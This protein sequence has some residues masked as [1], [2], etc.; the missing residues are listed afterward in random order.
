MVNSYV[1]KIFS[2]KLIPIGNTGNINYFIGVQHEVTV[3]VEKKKRKI[4]SINDEND[5]EVKNKKA[6][7]STSKG[8]IELFFF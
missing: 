5:I 2:K 6:K 7:P 3:T 8:E 4:D 1:L